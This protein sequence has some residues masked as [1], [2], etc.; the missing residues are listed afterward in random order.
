MPEIFNSVLDLVRSLGISSVSHAAHYPWRKALV[1]A[2]WEDLA[3]PLEGAE[4]LRAAQRKL[5]HPHP[6]WPNTWREL[7]GLVEFVPTE[8][9]AVVATE[10]GQVEIVLFAPNLAR[11][12]YDLGSGPTPEPVPYAI[13]KPLEEWEP[14]AAK[15]LETPEAYLLV[16]EA[17]VVGVDRRTAQ[18]FFA[19]AAGRLL[20]ADV[21]V[22]WGPGGALRHRT[23][24]FEGESI[25][26]LGERATAWNRRGRRH[27]LWNTDPGGYG[28]GD[29]PINLNIPAYVGL[30]PHGEEEPARSYLAFYENPHYA[31]FDLGR[32][33]DNVAEHLFR[34]GALRY[35]VAAGPV[36]ALLERYTELTGRH[37]LQP[38]WMLGYQQSRWSYIPE[39]RVRKLARDFRAHDVPCDVLHLDIDYMDGFR[40]FT[41]DREK[42][43]LPRLTADLAE[44]GFKT[45]AIV[46]PGV[47]KDLGYEVYREGL[48]G[49]HFCALPDGDVFHAPVWPGLCAFPDFTSP[50]ARSWW[51]EN[52]RALTDAG[53]AG[54]WDDMNEPAVFSAGKDP[55]LPWV[56]RHA[57]EGRGGDHAEAHNLYG[58]EMTHANYEGLARLQPDRRPVIIT[59]SGWAGV[60]RYATGWTGDNESTW[61]SLRLTLP[62]VMGLG[63]SGLGF[64]GADVGGFVGEADGELFTRWA[65][66]S[67]FLPFFRAHTAIGTA[68]QEPWSYGEPYLSIVRRFIRLRYELLPYLYTAMWQ[69][70]EHGW[71]MARPLWW[72]DQHE[73][74]LWEV[75]DAFLCGDDL[76]VAPIVGVG[77]DRRT[78]PLPR[79]AWYDFAMNGVRVGPERFE[80]YAPLETL[81][82]YVREGTVL[83]LGEVGPS[84]EQ[85]PDRFLRL[86]LYPLVGDGQSVSWLYEDAGEGLAYREGE[87]RVSR[88]IM[89]RLGDRLT[90][91][92]EKTG[93]YGPPYEH[94]AL[95]LMG[96]ERA[97]GGV[98]ADDQVYPVLA[99]DGAQRTSIIAV[100]PFERL[101]ITLLPTPTI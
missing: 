35:Y 4:W 86:H 47:K 37:E 20:R 22:S 75:D 83:P 72:F 65:Q 38:L 80:R 3:R 23:A 19:D 31:E 27:V 15:L 88:F 46:D 97:P 12:H 63:L 28:V 78:V 87:R 53:I 40:V 26:G 36:P 57:L 13:A 58:L 18:L 85:R 69:L 76:L 61:D 84:V 10:G 62:L 70:A 101:E 99:H 51:A 89:E 59:R 100:P 74:W 41:W 91:T 73:E 25:Y 6:P 33:V 54:F 60:Q 96:Q 24:L 90:V 71:P 49:G 44:L 30:L 39:S 7:G 2:R 66:L 50:E 81:P 5:S 21:D 17:M 98:K 9:G 82:L 56:V 8:R 16:T 52:Y 34:G 45:I 14:V 64:T 94:V 55:T 43:D 11:V 29:D 48:Y 95:T 42:F 67:A 32:D 79:G 1:E 93:G 77:Q 68:D 92:W